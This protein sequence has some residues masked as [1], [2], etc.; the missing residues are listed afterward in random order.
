MHRT[1][2]ALKCMTGCRLSNRPV[3]EPLMR[4]SPRSVDL[5]GAGRIVPMNERRSQTLIVVQSCG[6]LNTEKHRNRSHAS[7]YIVLLIVLLGGHRLAQLAAY[8][9]VLCF[10]FSPSSSVART[11]FLCGVDHRQG[12]RCRAMIEFRC[13]WEI[14]CVRVGQHAKACVRVHALGSGLHAIGARR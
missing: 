11:T 3:Q 12:M 9:D 4:P 6:A 8:W 1:S 2:S 13:L 10:G 7:H 14:R 5:V